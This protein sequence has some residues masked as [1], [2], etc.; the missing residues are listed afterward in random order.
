[1]WP[2]IPPKNNSNWEFNMVHSHTKIEVHPI[3]RILSF[4]VYKPK[5]HIQT[6]THS[7]VTTM[8]HFAFSKGIKKNI[9]I[10]IVYIWRSM[11]TLW[12]VW[13]QLKHYNLF[14]PIYSISLTENRNKIKYCNCY[15][16]QASSSWH[17][18]RISH[19]CHQF[20][21]HL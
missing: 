21:K 10:N 17:F 15:M 13:L 11:K 8:I 3:S 7:I 1:M 18:L 4:Y 12:Y 5:C 20:A 9:I 2:L 14:I 19:I 6:H 16:D